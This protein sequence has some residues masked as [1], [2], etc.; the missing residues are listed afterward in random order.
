MN[1][2]KSLIQKEEY[3]SLAINKYILQT[4]TIPKDTNDFLD[5]EKL[6]VEDYLGVHFNKKNPITKKNIV[7]T[8]GTDNN[9]YIKG[10]IENINEYKDEYKYLYNFYVNKVFRVNTIPPK[11]ILPADLEKG[12][13]VLYNNIQKEIASVITKNINSIVLPSQNCNTGK[14]FYE[15]KNEKLTYKYCKVI[16][17]S[18]EIYQ[19]APVYL[20]NL[21]DLSYIKVGIGEK[22]YV[23]DGN[24][25]Y[26]Y[27]Y[28]GNSSWI[29][30]GTG[31]TTGQVN[32]DITMQERILSYIPDS[33]DLVIRNNGGCMLANGD[34]FCWGSNEYKKAGIETRGQLDTSLTPNYVNTPVMLKVQIDNIEVEDETLDLISK[35]WY[36]NPYRVKFEKMA[37]NDK[38][39]CG[40]SPIFDYYES[41]I[42]YK[43]GG[44]LYCNGNLNL[45]Y[46]DLENNSIPNVTTSILRRYKSLDAYG[47]KG[48]YNSTAIYLK[49]IVMVNDTTV[50]LSD[51]GKIYTTGSNNKGSLGN[52]DTNYNNYTNNLIEINPSDIEFKRI[53]ALRDI[54]CFGALDE[55]NNFWI[56]GERSN[57]TIY[58]K[59][60][61][62]SNSKKFNEE[63]IFVNSKEFV[64]KGVDN[65][66]YRTYNDISVKDL[67]IDGNA[68]SVSVYDYNSKE[69]LLYVDKDM[70]L[71]GT[72]ELIK[73]KDKDFNN[74]YSEDNSI[75][76]SA[77]DELNT[78][79]N[80]IN[81]NSYANF[82]NVTIFKSLIETT[83]F[84]KSE[85]I[86]DFET[87]Y[88]GWTFLEKPTISNYTDQWLKDY[89][90]YND[91]TNI[92]LGRF[93]RYTYSG[94]IYIAKN[95]GTE[96]ISKTYNFGSK[97]ANKEIKIKFDIYAFAYKDWIDLKPNIFKTFI[98]N[99]QEE[100]SNID[101]VDYNTSSYSTK[102]NRA[103]RIHFEY[104]TSIDEEG[105]VTLGFGANFPNVDIVDFNWGIDN[106]SL[107]IY[108][109]SD[110]KF[111][112]NKT[113]IENFEENTYG[114]TYPNGPDP[115]LNQ[116]YFSTYPRYKY[117]PI[118]TSAGFYFSNI[119]HGYYF[120]G[121]FGKSNGYQGKN[122]GSQEVYKEFNFGPNFAN[123][124]V[125]IYFTFFKIDDWGINDKFYYFFNDTK[126]SYSISDM[127]NYPNKY[128][129]LNLKGTN[130][131]ID[132][133]KYKKLATRQLDSNGK[134]KI[135]FGADL[136]NNIDKTSWGVDYIRIELSSTETIP[137]VNEESEVI[138]LPYICTMTGIGSSSQMYC[139]GNV[140][141][142]IPILSTS[143]YDVDKIST[144]NKLF[145]TQESDV[146]TQMAFDNFNN[147]G[148]L[149]LKY[150]TY[151]GGFD[152][153]FY[154]K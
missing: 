137:E 145:V 68:L 148:N 140:G 15:L 84:Y 124:Y 127:I 76:T 74:C 118:N 123:K 9:A 49:D 132:Q 106:V 79:N 114:W 25:W 16:G 64:L 73:C 18:I 122:D 75:F 31:R 51:T 129:P 13:Q 91:G 44:D 50:L 87:N 37:M 55:N 134:I 38:N 80:I 63:G 139:W 95:D 103:K 26:E 17:N 130:T 46:F 14:Y 33:K 136:S 117:D 105:K 110:I 135:G 112:E 81:N 30:S 8:F 34:I 41:G 12:T 92:F 99:S 152:Y 40:I 28:E 98:N 48:E 23:K 109:G 27:Y 90:I 4:G 131:T 60:T 82:S 77:F 11:S 57:G 111:D 89:P 78:K 62:L 5:W 113:Y 35:R 147:S 61:I 6:M 70:Q 150:P 116:T 66:Y 59:P 71:K 133:V 108:D 119:T 39:V 36:N 138:S 107:S 146:H 20:D 151:I 42:R 101:I 143:L 102:P 1:D 43:I 21:D 85:Y 53:Y 29:P 97:N 3:L 52:G 56:W 120:L 45:S 96:E 100:I 32:D 126:Y 58:N 2:I 54:K 65:K 83:I 125:T 88:S 104:L 154:F 128:G 67:G 153:A 7:V 72:E 144:I 121:R 149:F 69:Y 10:A 94:K 47:T 141:R 142:S 19:N 24:S 86:D 115:S 22:A 93:G